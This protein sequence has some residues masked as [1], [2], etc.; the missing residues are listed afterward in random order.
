MRWPVKGPVTK[1]TG[2]SY[3]NV[4]E[5]EG[6]LFTSISLRRT[7][8]DCWRNIL[9]CALLQ[10]QEFR[11]TWDRWSVGLC[12]LLGRFGRGEG[13]KVTEVTPLHVHFPRI[14]FLSFQKLLVRKCIFRG[15]RA[16]LTSG[17]M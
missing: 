14:H 10:K 15:S 6:A 11:G 12:I 5:M 7:K 8:L 4:N 2:V 1:H 16:G 13:C 17:L 3:Y 9:I